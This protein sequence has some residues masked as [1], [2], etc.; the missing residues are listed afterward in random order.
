MTAH[1]NVTRASV[2]HGA[3][4]PVAATGSRQQ[5]D[6]DQ[7]ADVAQDV[8]GHRRRVEEPLARE[9][10]DQ[11][12]VCGGNLLGGG[13]ERR[14]AELA[15]PRGERLRQR[16]AQLPALAGVAAPQA[17][18]AR[19]EALVLVLEQDR[20]ATALEE[21]REAPV[22]HDRYVL[23]RRGRAQ[24]LDQ[25]LDRP[26]DPLCEYREHQLVLR[27][28]VPVEGALREAGALQDGADGR[29]AVAVLGEDGRGG[30]EDRV[31]AARV[32]RARA[33]DATAWLWFD[34]HRLR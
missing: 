15:R 32:L 19:G 16:L 8:V 28:E 30:V 25:L 6:V 2:E 18:G 34:S 29:T 23:V 4:L 13:V 12:E 33:A 22:C 20:V 10:A 17:R 21:L 11:R 7:A 1:G 3:F 26:L 5:P 27:L 14:R 9:A 31:P 24:H